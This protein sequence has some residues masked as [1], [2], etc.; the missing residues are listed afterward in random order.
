MN[1]FGDIVKHTGMSFNSAV[2]V[3]GQRW[4]GGY[5]GPTARWPVF[6]TATAGVS[7]MQARSTLMWSLG[8]NGG[9]DTMTGYGSSSYSILNQNASANIIWSFAPRW[10]LRVKDNYSYSDDPFQPFFSYLGN[11][12][13]N[14]PNPVIYFP[15]AVV[16]TNR[17]EVDLTYVLGPHDTL[18]FSG[19]ESFQ[20]FLRGYG[21]SPI[22]NEPSLWNSTTYSGGGFY[23][24]NISAR[25]N[26]GGGYTFQAMDFGH[27]QSRA[28]VNMLQAFASYKI[29]TALSISGWAGP[30]FTN[31]KDLIPIY[32]FPSG[33]LIQ[34][35]HNSYLDAAEGG[36][37]TWQVSPNNAFGAQVSHSVTNG[38]GLFGVIKAYQASATY[39]RVLARKWTLVL[40]FLYMDDVSLLPQLE[41]FLRSDQGTI[42]LT[43][44]INDSWSLRT[45]YAYMH[46]SSNYYSFN[47]LP[48]NG[49]ISGLGLTLQ[50]VWNHSLGR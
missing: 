21:G 36:S 41:S 26:V 34:T 33:C 24:H 2:G 37:I 18:N 11:P 15:Q 44:T 1:L 39:S 46:Q 30:E 20:H 4:T 23:Q 38:G 19:G 42:G 17:G 49:D 9:V 12:T 22:P 31:S 3:V 14:N 5:A 6:Y 7:V 25:L 35:Q 43:H 16:E 8:Y 45:Y 48:I 28:G 32:C 50:Y 40:G 27:G 10:Q 29:T 47:G 13:P